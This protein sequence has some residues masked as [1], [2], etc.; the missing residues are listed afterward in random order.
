MVSLLIFCVALALPPHVLPQ[1]KT[2]PAALTPAEAYQKVRSADREFLRRQPNLLEA[3]L[4]EMMNLARQEQSRLAEQYL[5][6]FKLE[7]W[8][9][10]NLLALGRLHLLADQPKGAETAA[11]SYLSQSPPAAH[12]AEPFKLLLWSLVKQ[13][14]LTEATEVAARLLNEPALDA[15]GD[16]Y[17][18]SLINSLKVTARDKA[19]LMAERRFQL[20]SRVSAGNAGSRV[21][22]IAQRAEDLGE[23]YSESGYQEKAL[24]F[25]NA[26][27][28]KIK[29]LPQPAEEMELA[30]RILSGAVRRVELVGKA[31]PQISGS[32]YIDLDTFKLE[33]KRGKIVLIDFFLHSCPPCVVEL[34]MLDALREK[35]G[36]Q[37]L[38]V[39]VVTAYQGYFGERENVPPDEEL[40]ALKQLKSAKKSGT[41]FVIGEKSNF[42]DYGVVALP[43]A[44][45]IDRSG[46]VIM[47]KRHPGAGELEEL[48]KRA[49]TITAGQH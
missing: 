7:E 29:T 15:E 27:L 9:G 22:S 26:E 2:D 42:A 44:A 11:S 48:I 47:V 41:G 39:V 14:K 8:K 23:L 25:L 35:Y 30:Q 13:G 24:A 20:L 19:I 1:V 3:D 33:T 45:L 43:A 17:V 49:L 18:Q 16:G 10:D 31:A 4:S 28:V 37:G 34:S 32:E 38:E 5:L 21:M 46:K 36:P 6:R 12:T 40:L